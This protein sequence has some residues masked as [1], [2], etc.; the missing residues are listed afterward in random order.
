[1]QPSDDEIRAMLAGAY[2]AGFMASA[3]GWNGEWPFEGVDPKT[4]EAWV[5]CRDAYVE[6]GDI[7]LDWVIVGGES[8]PGARVWLGFEDAARSIRD[9]CAAA[10]VAFFMKQMAGERKASMPPIPTDL[11]IREFPHD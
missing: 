1:M 10:G 8:G 7:G 3:E 5:E 2:E 6:A 9:Q 4:D 11:M